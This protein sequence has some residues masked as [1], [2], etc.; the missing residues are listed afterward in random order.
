MGIRCNRDTLYPQKLALTSPTGGGHSVGVVRSR[1]ED[2]E[3]AFVYS[4]LFLA[5]KCP[6]RPTSHTQCLALAFRELA[7]EQDYPLI[8]VDCTSLFSARAAA[9]LGL[10]CV[11]TMR[12]EDYCHNGEPIFRPE[13]PHDQVATYVQRLRT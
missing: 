5:S 1:T 12:Y 2:T 13:P 6:L 10:Q 4:F 7:K 11:F 8:R 3:Y 9:R